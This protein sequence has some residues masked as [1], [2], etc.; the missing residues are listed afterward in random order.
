MHKLACHSCTCTSDRACECT[1]LDVLTETISELAL[2]WQDSLYRI[3]RGEEP[4]RIVLCVKD[5]RFSVSSMKLT[6]REPG[7]KSQRAPRNCRYQWNRERFYGIKVSHVRVIFK[8][9]AEIS[10]TCYHYNLCKV[11]DHKTFHSLIVEKRK[12]MFKTRYVLADETR[13]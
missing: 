8:L 3:I 11:N 12:R 13:I 6:I 2:A 7:R 9:S 4:C 10:A 5:Y 1:P